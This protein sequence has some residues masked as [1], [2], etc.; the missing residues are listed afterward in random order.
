MTALVEAPHLG[1][2][3]F[4]SNF[5]CLFERSREDQMDGVGRITRTDRPDEFP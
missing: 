3:V 2:T 1:Q 5:R 4:A